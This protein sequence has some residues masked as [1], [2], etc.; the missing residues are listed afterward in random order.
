MVWI[1]INNQIITTPGKQNSKTFPCLLIKFHDFKIKSCQILI[2]RDS[3]KIDPLA[4]GLVE[5]WVKCPTGQ[6]FWSL[7]R[8]FPKFLYF[9]PSARNNQL[10]KF[11]NSMTFPWPTQSFL[12]F[13]D[14]S[15]PGMQVAHSMTLHDLYMTVWTLFKYL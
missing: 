4:K 15:R 14:F 10:A 12:I 6:K 7:T 8:K 5:Q 11:W 3:S 2:S 1:I 13:Q 9:E